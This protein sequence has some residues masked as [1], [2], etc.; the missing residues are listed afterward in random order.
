MTRA[1]WRWALCLGCSGCLGV[2]AVGTALAQAL[3]ASAAASAQTSAQTSAHVP[4]A[5]PPAELFFGKPDIETARLSPSGNWL[6]ASIGMANGRF[7]LAVFAVD[8]SAP[9]A[10]VAHFRDT[11]LGHF[12]WVNDERLVYNVVDLERGSGDPRYAPGLF[13]VKRDGSETR[14]LV[15]MQYFRITGAARPGD[16]TLSPAH[17]LLHV[18]QGMGDEV[19]VGEWVFSRWGEVQALIPKRL[20]VVTGQLRSIAFG[21]PAGA[22]GW[23]FDAAGR[24]PV[25]LVR[26]QGRL[27]VHWRAQADADAADAWREIG[28]FDAL[29]AP[30]APRGVDS[31]GRLYV[32][33][34]EGPN[35]VQVLKRYDFE[36]RRPEAAALVST[37]GFDFTGTVLVDGNDG[38]FVGVR[39]ETDGETTVWFEPRLKA[40][41]EVI[42]RRLPGHVNRLSCRRCLQADRT[43][44]VYS[45]S[46]QD[47]GQYWV[48]R[49]EA[50]APTLWRAVGQ[51]RK[52]VNPMQMATL[53][54]H[55]Y[56]ARDGRGIPVWVTT[57]AR[58]AAG[59]R[60]AVVLVHGGPWVRG[61]H[62][63]WEP[64]AQFLASRGY[65]VIEPEFR[66]STGYGTA[67]FRAGWKQWGRAMQDDLADAVAWA[68]GKQLIDPKR[69]CI[70]GASYG[71]YATLMGLVRQPEVYRCGAAWVAVAE[72]RLL[73]ESS[74]ESDQGE[75][76]RLYTLPAMLGD[77]VADADA[78]R[79][80]SP[81]EQAARLKAPLLLAYG[82]LD[83]RVPLEH[84]TRLRTALKAAGHEPE[85]VVYE[86]EGHYWQRAD[87]RVDFARRLELF[88]AR[89]LQGS[90]QAGTAALP[91]PK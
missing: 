48:W 35:G 43:V 83:R 33:V 77:P 17:M 82:E 37:P 24:P 36:A 70:A 4:A 32:T 5:P 66:G 65:V 69:V 85:F 64:W 76:A 46:D 50:D 71:G 28:D 41:Q 8:G 10:V 86:G 61:G 26:R 27:H 22:T 56:A 59:P 67:H 63:A 16:R 52:G 72:P 3:P 9:P 90:A 54:L 49:G 73:F 29:Q 2:L 14:L 62:W 75:E 53:D 13:S 19:V 20:N 84:G 55:R 44:L 6:A 51:R 60:P 38:Q 18:P 39:A 79:E 42:D 34:P 47:P 12:E 45:W 57:P 87:T 23:L 68:A 1:G 31:A 80:V 78:L 25:A 7:A 81:V 40:L 89:H 15:K 11:D 74:W 91:S 88:L 30:W 58:P 21:M